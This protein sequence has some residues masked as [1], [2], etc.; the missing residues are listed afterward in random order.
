MIELAAVSLFALN[1]GVTLYRPP[2]H[3]RLAQKH[4][5]H[6]KEQHEIVQTT[7]D[8]FALTV[9]SLFGVLGTVAVISST[10]LLPFHSELES[11]FCVD[12]GCHGSASIRS[13]VHFEVYVC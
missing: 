6:R 1:I 2:A 11:R 10:M 8:R 3:L 9:D 7:V 4:R 5:F 13:H 12:S